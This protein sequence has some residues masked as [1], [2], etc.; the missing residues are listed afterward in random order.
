MAIVITAREK[1][2]LRDVSIPPR[3]E[4]LLK[5]SAEAKQ[6]EPNVEKIAQF[7]AEDIS[8]SA[9]VLQI[10]NSVAYRRANR[11]KSIQQAVMLLGFRRV[12]PLVK[13]VALKSSISTDSELDS[14]WDMTNTIAHAASHAASLL[15]RH[16]LVDNAYML[17]LFH[18]S[19]IPMMF[20]AF[21]G[22]NLCYEQLAE[23][24]VKAL[25]EEER[26]RFGTSHPTLGA[27]IGQEW[28]LPKQLIQIIYYMQDSEGLFQSGELTDQEL[29][30]LSI[31]K[32]ARRAV[33]EKLGE[34]YEEEWLQVEEEIPQFL[35]ID[36]TQLEEL[37]V[38]LQE[39]VV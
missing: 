12:F 5:I 1:Q 25:V 3:P 2:I 23:S 36:E 38:Q 22:Y 33:A 16:G 11:I 19:G 32:I 34:N 9:A 30:L 17:G 24:G 29:E 15:G 21:Q 35:G 31:L 20:Q 8:I 28:K 6:A 26:A 14:F 4:I 13:A 18:L 7:I 37:I 27:L 10:V 39:A